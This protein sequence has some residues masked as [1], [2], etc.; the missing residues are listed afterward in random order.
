M[1]NLYENKNKGKANLED[2]V[3]EDMNRD[4]VILSHLK[5]QK[6]TENNRKVQHTFGIQSTLPMCVLTPNNF[7]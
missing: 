4:I 3:A 5:V 7:I 2:G 1:P 6:V